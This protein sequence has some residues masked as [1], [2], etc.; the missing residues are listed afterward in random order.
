MR[1]LSLHV[2]AFVLVIASSALAQP[3]PQ[4]SPTHAL[5][6][7]PMFLKFG[8]IKWQ[9]MAPDL[10]KDSPEISILRIDPKTKATQLMIRV[11][12]NFHVTKHWHTANETHTILSGT[13][14]MECDGKRAELGPSSFNYIPRK[15]IHEAWTKP[16]EGA[17]LFITVDS[18][19]DVNWVEG[20]PRP[21]SRR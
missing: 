18:G 15:M 6:G 9:K 17:L 19:W 14:I 5:P 11:P 3:A 1:R 4:H 20:P 12:P 10:G 21:M 7:D 13:F 2:V 16:N 8:D